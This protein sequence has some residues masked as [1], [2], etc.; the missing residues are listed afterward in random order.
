MPTLTLESEEVQPAVQ[1][2]EHVELAAAPVMDEAAV[3][4]A[5]LHVMVV[6][7]T[8]QS[9]EQVSEQ[10]LRSPVEAVVDSSPLE[11]ANQHRLLSSH[12]KP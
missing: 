10:Q 6:G 9:L 11:L 4:R 8:L 12:S 3:L 7:P 1:E 2:R 5:G